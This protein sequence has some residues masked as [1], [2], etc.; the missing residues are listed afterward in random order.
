MEKSNIFIGLTKSGLRYAILLRRDKDSPW[1]QVESA[2][3]RLD[4]EAYINDIVD[5]VWDINEAEGD[6][7][8]DDAPASP[9]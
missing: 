9:P 4:A 7:W 3:T 5:P 6:S 1:V 8:G 2:R